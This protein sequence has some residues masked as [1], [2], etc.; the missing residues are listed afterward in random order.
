M[1]GAHRPNATI[2]KQS[3]AGVA[4]IR[5]ARDSGA[6]AGARLIHCTIHKH[7]GRLMVSVEA[8][9]CSDRPELARVLLAYVLASSQCLQEFDHRGAGGRILQ[10]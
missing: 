6:F 2:W 8:G 9:K 5:H 10:A 3:A 4:R 7:A 1:S